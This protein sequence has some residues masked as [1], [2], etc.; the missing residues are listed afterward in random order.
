[1]ADLEKNGVCCNELK[2][3]QTGTFRRAAHGNIRFLETFHAFRGAVVG[4]IDIEISLST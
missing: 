3:I 2:I 1:L 4:E